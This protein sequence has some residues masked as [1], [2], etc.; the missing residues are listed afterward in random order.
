M[1][2]SKLLPAPD[3]SLLGDEVKTGGVTKLINYG[4]PET[5]SCFYAP[6]VTISAVAPRHMLRVL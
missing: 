3:Y 5:S 6:S 2:V 1:R 4:A